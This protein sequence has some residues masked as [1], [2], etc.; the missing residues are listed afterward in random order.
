GAR[1]AKDRGGQE[2]QVLQGTVRHF[3]QISGA[4]GLLLILGLPLLAW[5]I[6]TAPLRLDFLTPYIQEALN[7]G[8]DSYR[9]TLGGTALYWAGERHMFDIRAID[10]EVWTATGQP[11]ITLPDLSFSLSLKAL[12]Q[13]V[14]APHVIKIRDGRLHLR[15]TLQGLSAAAQGIPQA[16]ERDS[17]ASLMGGLVEALLT[18]SDSA[19]PTGHLE[20]IR[21]TGGTVSIDDQV[22]GVTWTATDI[23]LE[24]T[25]DREG[26]NAYSRLLV[27]MADGPVPVTL[28]GRHAVHKRQSSLVL[29]FT[30]LRPAA[31]A[32]AVPLLGDLAGFDLP[33]AGTLSGRLEHDGPLHPLGFS[34]TGDS[35]VVTLP[36]PYTAR[37]DV[38]SLTLQGTIAPDF[39]S[40]VLDKGILD[41]GGPRLEL[42]AALTWT[43][44]P[45]VPRPAADEPAPGA[46]QI[47]SDKADRPGQTGAG[48]GDSK[49][50]KGRRFPLLPPLPSPGIRAPL[51][52]PGP[53][54]SPAGRL[55]VAADAVLRAIPLNDLMRYWPAGV[56]PDPRAWIWTSLR[57][58][59]IEQA[60]F[61]A[62]LGGADATGLKVEGLY[63][64]LTVRDATIDYLAPMPP[65]R[66]AA[67][68]VI[69]HPSRLEITAHS[70][71]VHDLHI[72]KGKVVITGLDQ[73]DQFCHIDLTVAGP[74]KDA[75]Q[76]VDSE[77]L[78]YVTALGLP[79]AQVRG[80]TVTRLLLDFPVK[81]SLT[82]DR[83]AV[84][85]EA[86]LSD[87]AL[88]VSGRDLTHGT[89][90]L[91]VD[92]EKLHASSRAIVGGAP[93]HLDWQEFFNRRLSPVRSHYTMRGS[94]DNAQRRALGLDFP[95]FIPPY[96]N[97]PV[98]TDLTATVGFDG[99]G[100]L[101]AEADLTAGGME[102]AGVGW[103]KSPG[104]PARARATLHFTSGGVH[105]ISHFI[106]QADNEADVAGRVT[107]T[108]AGRLDRIILDRLQVGRTDLAGTLALT[109]GGEVHLH[110]QGAAFDAAPLL[111]SP[112]GSVSSDG[113]A[114]PD[115]ILEVA[116][117]RLWGS[118]EGF[119]TNVAL[120]ARRENGGWHHGHLNASLGPKGSFK[121]T[122]A[123][124]PSD[125]VPPAGGD[126]TD[127]A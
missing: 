120:S 71:G 73:I 99:L 15:R 57:D 23:D 40:L 104:Q 51:P 112:A 101:I 48:L 79:S 96:L 114:A 95:P 50:K 91:V 46:A 113:P 98:R 88:S 20:R 65:V 3:F 64:E 78:G 11:V 62:S 63:G 85:V 21:L 74:V 14:I 70:G 39:H 116:V 9:F 1:A 108:S 27:Q 125:A 111:A 100:T 92:N 94:F 87:L 31:L 55:T 26:I 10:V 22:L 56:A 77:P 126:T 89:L 118:E 6:S 53:P 42:A 127:D 4:F 8:S 103:Y 17:A 34:I 107:F 47:L 45:A 123:P 16:A 60:R 86:Q 80:T 41:L 105:D 28:T 109:Q 49:W 84:K 58:G 37:Y 69:F 119:F 72:P 30:N 122:L 67:A 7:A 82:L 117:A 29:A 19:Y 61:T 76:L 106:L 59:L 36:S 66:H 38:H 121:A 54:P 81:K 24:L 2:D 97:G 83:L 102:I 115:L 93:V 12:R 25:R 32:H 52:E 33:V 35:G 13:G 75:L 5:R 44:P 90:A 68:T 110:L 18:P 43:P 124:R